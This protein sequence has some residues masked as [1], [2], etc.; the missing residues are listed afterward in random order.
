LLLL[1]SDHALDEPFWR[2]VALE[3]G[4][5]FQQTLDPSQL[6][7]LLR[8]N[9]PS[10]VF[11][12]ATPANESAISEILVRDAP[13]AKI[14][15]LVD[16]ETNHY[17]LLGTY[18]LFSN[19]V[20]RQYDARASAI[21]ARLFQAVANPQARDILSTFSAT[22]Q[23][24]IPISRS[25]E[26]TDAA[27]QVEILCEEL[28]LGSRLTA[29]FVSAVDELLMNA[30]F[31][32]PVVG[33]NNRYRRQVRRDCDYA[34]LDREQIE[35]RTVHTDHFVGAS[36]TDQFG[37]F[38][39]DYIPLLLDKNS[40]RD[41]YRINPTDRGAG[42]GLSKSLQSGISLVFHCQPRKRTEVVVLANRAKSFRDAL[43]GFRFFS[44]IV[45]EPPRA[46]ALRH[47]IR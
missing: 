17:P 16:P 39:K 43:N 37:S 10:L 34:F 46:Q 25:S 30:I 2:A 26:R 42:L 14:T 19:L 13:Q 44:I 36:V 29:H 1:Y 12:D 23:S 35:V 31:D 47:N 5:E 15:A 18:S 11:W 3:N 38:Q 20:L 6:S 4:F 24:R 9:R 7:I 22:A 33:A 40:R 45:D 21:Y 8:Q 32:A 41:H 28:K 27:R